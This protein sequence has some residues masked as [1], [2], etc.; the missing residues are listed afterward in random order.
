MIGGALAKVF[1]KVLDRIGMRAGQHP[2]S[3]VGYPY[4]IMV[5]KR[6]IEGEE[7]LSDDKGPTTFD[8]PEYTAINRARL[9]HLE[10]LKLPINGRTVLDVGCGVGHLAQFFVDRGCKV[11]CIDGREQNVFA[12]R[13]RYPGLTGHIANVE[14][15][16]LSQYGIFD[17]VFCYGL[18]YHL[19]NPS[20]A[21]RNMAS[22]CRE[23]LLLETMVCDHKLPILAVTDESAAF[24]QALRGLGCC[25]SPSFVVMVLSRLGFRFIY[26]PKR[27]PEYKDFRIKWKN[28]LD[29]QRHGHPLRCVFIASRAELQNSHLVS[30]YEA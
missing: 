7:V 20:M 4:P 8:Q 22:V 2:Y 12:L 9:A 28:N 18:L 13:M 23:F 1:K 24:S 29:W 3:V 26:A 15:E 19:E 27:Y 5:R 6:C 11:V 10:S 25:P 17:I 30:L 16:P 21:L 14:T